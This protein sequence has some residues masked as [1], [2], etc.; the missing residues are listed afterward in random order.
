[1]K[2]KQEI[3]DEAIGLKKHNEVYLF[4][5]RPMTSLEVCYH[6]NFDESRLVIHNCSPNEYT[7]WQ[8][9][10]LLI[11]LKRNLLTTIQI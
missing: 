8:F 4:R 11:L 3:E 5:Q 6:D 2:F 1:M 7:E 10:I 9:V